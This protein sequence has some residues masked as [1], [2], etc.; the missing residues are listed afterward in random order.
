ME[1][2]STEIGFRRLVEESPIGICVIQGGRYRYINPKLAATFGYSPE[3]LPGRAAVAGDR[4]LG[5]TDLTA[6]RGEAAL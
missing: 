3:E 2:P 6:R 1:R 5:Q 4:H